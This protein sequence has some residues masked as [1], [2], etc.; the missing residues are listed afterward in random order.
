MAFGD[1]EEVLLP[2]GKS[3]QPSKLEKVSAAT[4]S[5]FFAFC[6]SDKALGPSKS[7]FGLAKVGR[8]EVTKG[9]IHLIKHVR[10]KESI[11]DGG[12]GQILYALY[13]G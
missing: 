1:K 13:L 10:P 11:S 5:R 12:E 8:N 3:N 4:S 2:I 6:H 9:K 7:R